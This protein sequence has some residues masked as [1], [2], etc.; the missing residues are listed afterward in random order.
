MKTSKS[1]S[2]P[3]Y[4]NQPMYRTRSRNTQNTN[5]KTL[6]HASSQ[7]VYYYSHQR[8]NNSN[9][10][11]SSPVPQISLKSTLHQSLHTFQQKRGPRSPPTYM[12]NAAIATSQRLIKR[13]PR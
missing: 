2:L 3:A 6:T 12:S 4:P 7:P 8:S 9:N 1:N 11:Q 5:H 10:N 13:G